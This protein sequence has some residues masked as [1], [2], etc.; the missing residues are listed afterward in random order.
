VTYNGWPLYY[1]AGDEEPGDINGQGEED[2]FV[3]S[4]EG[5]KIDK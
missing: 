3:I 4:P 5:D 1:F 2:F